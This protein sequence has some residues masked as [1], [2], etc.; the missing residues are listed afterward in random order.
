[1]QGN[2]HVNRRDFNMDSVFAI[3]GTVMTVHLPAEI[4]HHTSDRLCAEADRLIERKHI[5]CIIF[6]FARTTFMDSSGIGMLIGRYK[7]MRFMGGTVLAANVGERVRR[8]LELS[9][10]GRIMDI[11]EGMPS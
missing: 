11:Y 3:A 5:R 8:M 4:D 2:D 7:R 9:G 1:M 10:I 6:D